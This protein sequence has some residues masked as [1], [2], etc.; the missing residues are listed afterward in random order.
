MPTG[1]KAT[2]VEQKYI[3]S[4]QEAANP[5]KQ[6]DLVE[7]RSTWVFGAVG[8]VGTAVAG[9]TLLAGTQ[10]L[11]QISWPVTAVI[12]GL[13]LVALGLSASTLMIRRKRLNPNNLSDAE[14][15]FD[16]MVP[17]RSL[18]A[19]LAVGALT[20][21]ILVAGVAGIVAYQSQD[22]AGA[23]LEWHH[24]T[25]GETLNLAVAIEALHKG[26][27][28]LVELTGTNDQGITTLYEAATEADQ[29]GKVS[30]DAEVP[31]TDS[32]AT[33]SLAVSKSEEPSATQPE[34]SSTLETV[35]IE[36]PSTPG[37]AAPSATV[38]SIVA[39]TTD[40][41]T[42]Y[43]FDELMRI[44]LGNQTLSPPRV[45]AFDS[46]IDQVPPLCG[47]SINKSEVVGNAYF[48]QQDNFIAWDRELMRELHPDFGPYAV[49]TVIA[50]E[51]S[52]WVQSKLGESKGTLYELQAD[53]FA[54][55]WGVSAEANDS[56]SLEFSEADRAAALLALD[57][58]DDV[59]DDSDGSMTS[60]SDRSVAFLEGSEGGMD[61]CLTMEEHDQAAA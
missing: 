56:D 13:T 60:L 15:Y 55:A 61:A 57:W 4:I 38:D 9:F 6:L 2:P 51:W 58:N 59:S 10:S 25:D 44:G 29:S 33:A 5:S 1:R 7:K 14:K 50:H 22:T 12:V 20:L 17:S 3:E 53:C 40:S 48:C 42:G 41:L 36:I 43:W 16:K 8:T 52:H 21:A 11:V 32:Y 34:K 47:G 39:S 28:I 37:V 45:V 26:D 31:L 30:A 49:A 23:T 54:G 19:S 24:T 35:S 18:R 27:V 46:R